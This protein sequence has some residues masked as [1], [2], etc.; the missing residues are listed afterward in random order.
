MTFQVYIY[1]LLSTGSIEE[2]IYQRQLSKQRYCF[3]NRYRFEVVR[4][5]CKKNSLSK[6]IVDGSSARSQVGLF[7]NIIDEMKIL[8]LTMFGF[9]FDS[10]QCTFLVAAPL[11]IDG[12][13]TIS[14]RATS[15]AT[16]SRSAARRRATRT[17]SPA[18]RAPAQV[19]FVMAVL[20]LRRSAVVL[21]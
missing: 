17:I 10:N 15:C 3:V 7:V 4:Q 16:S 18:A 1:R 8:L 21:E 12:R 19:E 2:K 6:S 14:S 11:D 9:V 13:R 5:H 20:R